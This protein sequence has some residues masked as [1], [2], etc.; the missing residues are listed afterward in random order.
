MPAF[1]DK[2]D[3]KRYGREIPRP[4]PNSSQPGEQ[5]RQSSGY[6]TPLRNEPAPGPRRARPY[7]DS[8]EQ[9]AKAHQ[10]RPADRNDRP[11]ERTSTATPRF[12][13]DRPAAQNDRPFQRD[14]RAAPKFRQDRPAPRTAENSEDYNEPQ[15]A[16][17]GIG[18]VESLLK[19]KP[20][21]VHRG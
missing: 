6:D 10:D 19:N 5:P 17:G 4:R 20:G 9:A 18:N 8:L 3:N 11:Y 1:S 13:Q 2:P 7:R 14:D 16:V 15:K 12:R 21:L